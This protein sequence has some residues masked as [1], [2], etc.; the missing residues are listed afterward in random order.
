PDARCF[1]Q[2]GDNHCSPWMSAILSDAL[3]AYA[4]Q[5]GGA[6]ADAARESIVKLGR[7]LAQEGRDGSGKPYYM[8][9]VGPGNDEVDTDDEHWGESAYVIAMAWFYGG[10]S[11]AA[12]AD[13]ATE[14][15][16]GFGANGVAPHMRSFN[17]QCR[18]AV[19]TSYYLK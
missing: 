3:D 15:V 5:R 1:A 6:A 14:L 8:M 16:D 17:W 19:A 4:T 18:S 12:L 10:K 11:E 7:I 9:G 2:G 13:A